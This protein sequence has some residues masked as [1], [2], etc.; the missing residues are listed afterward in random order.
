[1]LAIVQD[2]PSIHTDICF[3]VYSYISNLHC[4]NLGKTLSKYNTKPLIEYWYKTMRNSYE[5]FSKV[6][7]VNFEYINGQYLFDP[8]DSGYDYQSLQG[9]ELVSINNEPMNKYIVN[10]ISTYSLKYD[11]KRK[12]PYH[13]FTLND[14]VGEKVN[15]TLINTDNGSTINKEL[16]IDLQIEIVNSGSYLFKESDQNTEVSSNKKIIYSYSDNENNIGYIEVKDFMN[17][18]GKDLATTIESM[19]EFD[20][21]I[22]D[23]RDNYG[24]SRSYS[25]NYLYSSLYSDNITTKL[26]WFVPIS[27]SNKII[28]NKLLNRLF[29]QSSKDD[30]GFYYTREYNY[31]GKSSERKQNIY[32]LINS[33]T[34]SA[35]DGSVAIIKENKLGTIIGTNTN[36]EGIANSFY[37]SSLKN[38]G[39]VYIYFPSLSYNKNAT[40]N[41]LLTGKKVGIFVG[42]LAILA[43]I[44]M[45]I[46][47]LALNMDFSYVADWIGNVLWYRIVHIMQKKHKVI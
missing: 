42:V 8:M 37:S 21:I 5:Q 4:Y 17:S 7:C 15:V 46:S 39:L 30:K 14:S 22:I 10:N 36:G 33:R 40:N 1:M 25:M 28:N 45:I 27:N 3:P 6:Q 19:K 2:V 24:G 9:F 47:N 13:Y 38:S 18:Q 35:A 26:N 11:Y 29:Y 43:S 16:Y 34:G 31:R 32:Y 44:I 20:N 12:V 41:S 23:L